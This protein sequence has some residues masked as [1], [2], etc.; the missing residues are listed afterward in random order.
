MSRRGVVRVELHRYSATLSGPRIVPAAQAAA[1]RWQ[2]HPT[3]HHRSILVRKADLAAV[4]E[5]LDRLD[6]AI[7]VVGRDGEPLAWGGLLGS[8]SW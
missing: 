3:S 4:L 6:A 2:W 1:A 7:E 8:G 5:E